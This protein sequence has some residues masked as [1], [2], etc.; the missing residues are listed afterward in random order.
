MEQPQA[1]TPF[2]NPSVSRAS[3]VV[4][5]E[6]KETAAALANQ[7]ITFAS[8]VSEGDVL[9]ARDEWSRALDSYSAALALRSSDPH[10]LVSRSRCYSMLGQVAAAVADADRAVQADPLDVKAILQKAEAHFLAGDFE[11]GLVQYHRG[12]KLRPDM[13]EFRLGIQKAREAIDDALAGSTLQRPPQKYLRRSEERRQSLN[14]A[15]LGNASL[16]ASRSRGGGRAR[17]ARYN[18]I[19]GASDENADPGSSTFVTETPIAPDRASLSLPLPLPPHQQQQR[20]QTARPATAKST[21]S[22]RA[23]PK[24]AR[25]LLGRL[26][27]DREYLE[28]LLEDEQLAKHGDHVHRIAGQ[29]ISFLDQREDFW[30]QQRNPR[31]KPAATPQGLG[32]PA[33]AEPPTISPV[34]RR[35]R[36]QTARPSATRP[37]SPVSHT[38]ARRS[39]RLRRIAEQQAAAQ[40]QQRRPGSARKH[41]RRPSKPPA[42][43]AR[44]RRKYVQDSHLAM[45]SLESVQNA[46][47]HGDPEIGLK[48]AKDYLARLQTLDLPDKPKL[49][50]ALYSAMGN[51]YYTLGSYT[52]AVVHHRKDLEIANKYGLI[53]AIVRALQNMGKTY[54]A[55][56]DYELSAAHLL[57][58]LRIL[59][60][61]DRPQT[62]LAAVHLGLAEALVA[63]GDHEGAR[64]QISQCVAC[65]SEQTRASQKLFAQAHC[66]LAKVHLAQDRRDAA[67]EDLGRALQTAAGLKDHA[68]E[69]IIL[70]QTGNAYHAMGDDAK[71]TDY[72]KRAFQARQQAE[73]AA[74]GR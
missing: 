72:Q 65:T 57:R 49:L 67:I 58:A 30:R 46:L 39:V 56:E 28:G 42:E 2:F 43:S 19:G 62:E 73:N 59:Q 6:R 55:I 38:A 20:P 44:A 11:H 70:T 50:G 21:A 22:A 35:R 47:A 4:S 64:Q 36:P 37:R 10:A 69:A 9:L 5:K 29:G 61:N 32:D 17:S 12:N 7:A 45:Q 71:A 63:G 27:P 8:L 51:T 68:L 33:D 23:R 16:D 26:A 41:P 48:F 13:E 25:A 24:S 40:E 60:D 31:K 14:A 15:V 52:L 34:M 54:L 66:V 3:S 18:S 1:L 53:D 74:K